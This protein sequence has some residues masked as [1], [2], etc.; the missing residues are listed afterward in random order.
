MQPVPGSFAYPAALSRQGDSRDFQIEQF[1][2]RRISVA[3][4][5]QL[6]QA[7]D[8]YREMG[9]ALEER[10]N[11]QGFRLAYEEMM[12]GF[13]IPADVERVAVG[14]V[15]AEWFVAPGARQDRVLIY[16]HGGG[17]FMGNM[18]THGEMIARMARAAGVKALGLEFRLAP[19]NPFPAAV[20]DTLAA[21]R[22]L[23]AQGYDPKK[24]AIS[25]DSSGGCLTLAALVSFRYLGEPMPACAVPIS[26]VSTWE[27][28]GDSYESRLDQDPIVTREVVQFIASMYTDRP[29][30]TPLV[31]PLHA[32]L[33]GLPSMLVQVGGAEVLFDDSARIVE[34]AKAA[35]VQAELD[36]WPD[37]PHVWHC[38][39]PILPEGQQAIDK[40]AA[41]IKK[42][43]G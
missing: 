14:G 31:S 17:Y 22:A 37:M 40:M 24:I 7:C 11:V 2:T 21:Y 30:N 28:T 10:G 5:P 29:L 26:P 38:F 3:K 36:E 12:A 6:D 27:A 4:S 39:A 15:P 19:E 1:D 18:R 25:G 41:F 16:L 9:K 34:K 23:L 42:H 8:L 35:G 33:T 20:E 13:A 43:A 32:D